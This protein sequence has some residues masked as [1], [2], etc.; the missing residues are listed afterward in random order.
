MSWA[1]VSPR[2]PGVPVEVVAAAGCF[3][4]S[5]GLAAA[6]GTLPGSPSPVMLLLG[7]PL[8][9]LAG[10]VVLDLRPDERT[11]RVLA[12][13]ALVPA[14]DLA[15]AVVRSGP[16]LSAPEVTQAVAELAGLQVVA[17]AFV[18]PWSHRVETDRAWATG[19]LVLAAAGALAVLVGAWSSPPATLSYVGWA[20]VAAGCATFWASTAR[21]AALE[22]RTTRRRTS[23]LL[24][25]LA[26]A[27]VVLATGWL[28]FPGAADYF[29]CAALWLCAVASARL[30]FVTDFRPLDECILD[31]A[32]ALLTVGVSGLVAGLV[33]VG[34]G[35]THLP[36]PRA[37]AVFSGLL[38]FAMAAPA[39]LWVRRSILARRYGNG[40]ISPSDVELIT[41]DLHAQTEPRDLLDKAA[42]MVATASGS[43][44]ARII[45]G[46][47][48]PDVPGTW[49]VHPLV[50]GGDQVGAL[51]VEA[52]DQEGPELR[53][54][55]VVAQLL[56][57]V[58]LVAR[59]VG[60]AV[61]TEHARQD[62]A[63]ERDAERRRILGD[64]HDE[65]GPVLAGMSMRV[66]AALRT[67]PA[68][69]HDEL[70]ADLAADLARSRT[71]LR[72]IVAGITPSVLDDTD[73][74]SALA[75]LV[76][77]FQGVAG[78]PE[79]SLEVALDGVLPD[80]VQVAVY[81]SVAEGITNSLRHAQAT[82]ID[83]TVRCPQ[84]CVLVD[85]VD[86]GVGGPVVPGVGLSSLTQRADALGGHLHVGPT[87]PRGTRLHLELPSGTG[88]S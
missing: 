84:R 55:R 1:E 66:R 31:A 68:P 8:F 58:A 23:W 85:V 47:G 88:T 34:A 72:R 25:A 82:S 77:S 36:S 48:T 51:L 3:V 87:R 56:P 80:V 39:A 67:S 75:E 35:W 42:R 43:A 38:T 74:G 78:G 70:L 17:I 20:V 81:R 40:T 45:L 57:T 32:V 16:S 71:D 62:V 15:W 13:F 11:G 2:P 79:V 65:L 27:G 54:Q 10:G 69:E 5:A 61:E 24:V 18:V 46:E 6:T 76:R 28:L 14:L 52:P 33:W 22:S 60:L 30:P 9:A 59:A 19:S 37:S 41:A 7:W 50:V 44:S 21:A 4:L 26:T 29:T 73:L 63:R 12:V 83:V 53:Q 49:V 86:D 64:L